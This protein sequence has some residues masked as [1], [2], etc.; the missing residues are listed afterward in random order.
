MRTVPVRDLR[1]RDLSVA[2]P[3]RAAAIRGSRAVRIGSSAVLALTMLAGCRDAPHPPAATPTVAAVSQDDSGQLGVLINSAP[4]FDAR[5]GWSEGFVK[6]KG[7]GPGVVVGPGGGHPTVFAQSFSA[8]PGERFKVV[9]RAASGAGPKATARI[10]INWTDAGGRFLAVSSRTFE[11]TT[12]ETR[13]EESV[14]APAG[15]ASGTLYVV[16]DGEKSIVRYLEMRLLGGPHRSPSQAARTAGATP[17][18]SAAAKDASGAQANAAASFPKPP[19]LTPLD[20]SGRELSVAES[21]YYF[22]QAA[23]ALQRRARERGMDFIMYVMPDYN[24]PRLM[25]AIEQ[26]RRE[27]VK[28]LA[29]EP[30]GTWTAGVDTDWFWQQADSHWT[31]AAVRLTADEILYMWQTQAVENRRFSREMMDA[32]GRGFPV[33]LPGTGQP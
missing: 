9:A 27:G 16:A 28:V 1:V 31:E 17:T 21:Q 32:Y 22:Y 6:A 14:S 7:Q 24:I 29:Y 33:R 10:Q 20:G 30:Q 5:E 11:V 13:V 15:A 19:N 12:T 8:A 25:P 3:A 23:K 2:I 18:P 4:T 26:L